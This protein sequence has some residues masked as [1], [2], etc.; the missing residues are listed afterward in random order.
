MKPDFGSRRLQ[1][2]YFVFH[3]LVICSKNLTN[4]TFRGQVKK[5]I[6]VLALLYKAVSVEQLFGIGFVRWVL[7]GLVLQ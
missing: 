5:Q 3:F 2:F 1:V 7:I 6:L 4:I